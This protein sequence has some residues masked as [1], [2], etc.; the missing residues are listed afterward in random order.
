MRC[1]LCEGTGQ[2]PADTQC[3]ACEGRGHDM[4]GVGWPWESEDVETSEVTDGN[5]DP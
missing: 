5:H 4:S 3:E 2:C 1:P